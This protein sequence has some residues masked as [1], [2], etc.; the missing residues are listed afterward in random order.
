MKKIIQQIAGVCALVL[1][2][3]FMAVNASAMTS[4]ITG[5]TASDYNNYAGAV[6]GN[7]FD[8]NGIR[9]QEA[10]QPMIVADDP[11][12]VYYL[13]SWYYVC[14]QVEIEKGKV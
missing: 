9:P 6:V 7:D 4:S 12:W 8:A 13:G 3:T 10:I 14:N 1:M 11:C 2:G 5:I